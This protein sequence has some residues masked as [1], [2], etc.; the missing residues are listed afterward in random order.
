MTTTINNI[1]QQQNIDLAFDFIRYLLENPLEIDKIPND[2]TIRFR[3]FN[4]K[5]SN[6]PTDMKEQTTWITVKSSFEIAA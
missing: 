5:M 2:S 6:L 1:Q 4:S 3:A